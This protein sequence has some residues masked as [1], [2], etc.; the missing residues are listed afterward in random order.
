MNREGKL[1]ALLSTARVANVPSVVSNVWVGVILGMLRYQSDHFTPLPRQGLLLLP[2]AGV[3]L[4]LSGNFFNDWMDRKWDETH[5][6]ER[7]LPRRLFSPTLYAA[8]AALLATLGLASAFAA[9]HPS[10]WVAMGIAFSI[11]IYTLVHKRTTW[12]VIPMGLCRALLPLM[13]SVALFPYLDYV[14]PA[15]AALFCYIVGLSLTARYESLAEPPKWIGVMSRGLLLGVAVLVV[16]GN[17]KQF[18]EFA[19]N[20]AGVLPYLLWTSL[21]LRIWRKPIPVLV[22]RLLAGIPLVDAITLLPVSA[23]LFQGSADFLN[24]WAFACMLIPIIAFVSA[25]LLQRLAPAT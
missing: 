6:P 23:M 16:W 20:V 24:P 19:P 15:A 11:I 9:S 4:Y 14:W 22:S 25:L 1:H 17:K 21:S 12:G 10:G 3:F 13:G 18:V 7:A 8:T 5:R 2:L